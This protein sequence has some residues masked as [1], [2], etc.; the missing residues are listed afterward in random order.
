M[1]FQNSKDKLK[2]E[3]GRTNLSDD[4]KKDLN[5]SLAPYALLAFLRIA[6]TLLPQT[7]YI[8]P[9]EYF[10]S[11]EIVNEDIFNVE[12][13]RPWEFNATKPIR[14]VALPY[15]YAGLPIY[16][17]QLFSPFFKLFLG[18]DLI[19]PYFLLVV[20]RLTC[21]MLSFLN[22]WS[23]YKIC[24]IYGQNYRARLLTLASSY[25][26]LVYGTHT[27]SN[28]IEMVL[29]SLLIYFV[30]DCMYRSDQIISTDE[31]LQECY[32][33]TADMREK[34]RLSRLRK[35][36]PGH[37]FSS[38][39]II[40]SITVIG[41]FNRPTFLAFAFTP[42]FFWLH[43]GL[44][45]KS[46]GLSEFHL[47]ILLLGLCAL[48]MT[49]IMILIDSIY[50]GYLTWHEILQKKVSLES[51]FVMTPYNFIQ[52]N[53]YTSNLANH[54]LHPRITH[55]LLNMPLLYNVLALAAFSAVTSLLY[56]IVK[57][58]WSELPRIQSIIGLMTSAYI[59]PVTLLS[60]FPHQEPRFLIPITL[61]LVFLHS[62]RIRNVNEQQQISE[63]HDKGVKVFVKKEIAHGYKDKILTLWY[64]INMF[65]VLVYGFVHQAGVY[66]LLDHISVVM[67]EKPRLTTVHLVTSFVY[68]LPV[69]LLH[70]KQ[71]RVTAV[72]QKT[73]IRYQTT[74][75][76]FAYEM[77]LSDSVLNATLKAKSV[78]EESEVIWQEK[79]LKY[80]VYLALPT[81]RLSEF[82]M[83]AFKANLTYTVDQI[84]YPHISTEL[85]PDFSTGLFT[86]CEDHTADVCRE[87]NK[88]SLDF[89]LHYFSHIVHQCGLALIRIKM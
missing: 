23:L 25:V 75:D 9:D 11:I 3:S 67:R 86:E 66:P 30:A 20:P 8:Q 59:V 49:V 71:G 32:S 35:S 42:I 69:S 21:C 2:E 89:A 61:P 54:G 83:I 76:F 5:L 84:F 1:K 10:Q 39:A 73:G 82:Q 38:C 80:K 16:L 6:L 72:N 81:S 77:G 52:Y 53:M 36:L 4:E 74:R 31:Y 78:I 40:A 41:V 18:W 64:L 26:I 29:T 63:K 17:L 48:P 68:P 58:R 19:T 44:G 45:S 43:R 14:S 57:R 13:S 56:R 62:Q 47:R 24:T 33:K 12:A 60:I 65:L 37:S 7:G 22:D 28:A 27:F 88:F 46:V 55:V 70:L 51:N 15:L 50:F 79:R 85:M 34:V 87:T